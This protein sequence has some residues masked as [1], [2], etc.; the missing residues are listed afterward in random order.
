MRGLK[1]LVVVMGILLVAGLAV[2]IGTIIGRVTKLAAPPPVAERPLPPP[3]RPFGRTALTLPAGA[4][5]LEMR[6]AG[7][8][9]VLRIERADGSQAL[10]VIDPGTGTELGTIDLQSSNP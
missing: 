2:V 1:I 6:G 5:V 9:V 7:P 4:K 8:R 10:L 3:L